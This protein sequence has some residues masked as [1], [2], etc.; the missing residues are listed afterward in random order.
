MT[1]NFISTDQNVNCSISCYDTDK[2]SEIEEKLCMQ[3][4]KLK[5]ED[6]FYTGNGNIFD[7]SLT[8][9]ENNIKDGMIIFINKI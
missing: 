2:L 9:E 4:I 3:N 7:K 6:L 8:L 5:H 1:L